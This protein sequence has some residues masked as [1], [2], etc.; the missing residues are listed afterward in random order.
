MNVVD[1]EQSNP[2]TFYILQHTRVNSLLFVFVFNLP[3]FIRL[4]DVAWGATMTMSVYKMTINLQFLM[5]HSSHLRPKLAVKSIF[6]VTTIRWHLNIDRRLT[7]RISFSFRHLLKYHI[8][9]P[10]S[11]PPH[12]IAFGHWKKTFFFINVVVNSLQIHS[13]PASLVEFVIRGASNVLRIAGDRFIA[14]RR[15]AMFDATLRHFPMLNYFY[16]IWRG[17]EDDCTQTVKLKI[18]C[19]TCWMNFNETHV[20]H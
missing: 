8:V 1:V 4:C 10:S 18:R 6:D 5:V 14:C 16:E 20:P 3:I 12:L 13:F 2:L 11:P 15:S 9:K 19:A 7:R 17:A